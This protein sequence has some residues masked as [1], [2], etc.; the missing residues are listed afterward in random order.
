MVNVNVPTE[1]GSSEETITVSSDDVRAQILASLAI[2]RAMNR[3]A[4]VTGVKNG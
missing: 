1:D 4:R 3:L 2:A